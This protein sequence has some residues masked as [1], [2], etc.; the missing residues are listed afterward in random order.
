[1]QSFCSKLANTM[2]SKR[3]KEMK[4]KR[5]VSLR[6]E[7]KIFLVLFHKMNSEQFDILV[8]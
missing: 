3:A 8:F 4:I 1:M 5:E 6:T 7:I 2:N